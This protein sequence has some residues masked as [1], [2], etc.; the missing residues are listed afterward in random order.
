MHVMGGTWA[1]EN[2]TFAFLAE[3]NGRNRIMARFCGVRLIRVEVG[4]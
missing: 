2:S 3:A 4:P 1:N